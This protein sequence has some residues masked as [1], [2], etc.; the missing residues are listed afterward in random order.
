MPKMFHR[1]RGPADVLLATPVMD[2]PAASYTFALYE[3]ARVLET[4]GIRA[5]LALYQ[6]DAHVDDARNRIVRDFLEGPYK[7]LL[8][9]DSDLR[10]EPSDLVTLCGFDR[11][12]VGVGYPFKQD[13]EGFTVRF[14]DG[15]RIADEDGLLEVDT[16]ATGM[17]KIQRPV[18]EQLAELAE[19]FAPKSDRR[20]NIPCVFER[21]T[22][23][24]VRYGGDTHF[25]RKWQDIGGKIYVWPEM[26]LEHYGE[27]NWSGSL[28]HYLRK[29]EYGAIRAGLL[30]IQNGV[31]TFATYRDLV[32]AWG[33]DWS[34][35]AGLLSAAVELCRGKIVLE[36][37]SG[38]SSLAMAAA[39][40]VVHSVEH[41]EEWL[42]RLQSQSKDY[43]LNLNIHFS[44][45]VNGWY[46]E[47]PE[48]KADLVLIDGPPRHCAVRDR[49][50]DFPALLT[51]T[52]LVDDADD[53]VS[54]F[55]NRYGREIVVTG[56]AARPI[57]IV[58]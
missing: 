12:V 58:R 26:H 28:G 6:G 50:Y 45:L 24:G 20:S 39:G 44:P 4:A 34:V 42:D 30:E 51:G 2:R 37:G 8:F 3:S 46:S 1:A 35:D 11:P 13:Q 41:S 19:R 29:H 18:L 14:L 55:A 10:W 43:G 33:N 16:V 53:A 17:L 5:D 54:A 36:F 9:I 27:T 38:L 47:V 49:V 56:Q 21:A 23:N 31:D 25:C 22:L 52:L 48:V 57:A 32:D 40:A 7:T 15:P